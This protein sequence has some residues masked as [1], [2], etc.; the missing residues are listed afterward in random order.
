MDP[1]LQNMHQENTFGFT[2]VIE[3]TL[4]ELHP[5]FVDILGLRFQGLSLDAIGDAYG[6]T[7]ERIRQLA[8]QGTIEIRT[9]LDAFD[10]W[11]QEKIRRERFVGQSSLSA[12]L[13]VQDDL[14][15][16]TLIYALGWNHFQAPRTKSIYWTSEADPVSIFDKF[17]LALAPTKLEDFY[18]RAIETYNEPELI[19]SF[20][21]ASTKVSI[22][23]PGLLVRNS[24]KVRDAS[25]LIFR[26]EGRSLATVNLA[27]RFKMSERAIVAQL[28]RD[29]RFTRD[30]RS[31]VWELSEWTNRSVSDVR[32]A[33]EAVDK[34]LLEHGPLESMRLI[35]LASQL[36]PRS[37]ARYQQV[38]EDSKYGLNSEGNWDFVSNGAQQKTPREPKPNDKV[39]EAPGGLAKIV[40]DVNAE[41]LRGSGV[42]VNRRL[43]WIMGLYM[44]TK[45][46]AFQ[47]SIFPIKP[48]M[49]HRTPGGHNLSALKSF[50]EHFSL[51]AGCKLEIAFDKNRLLVQL[52]PGCDCHRSV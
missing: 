11:L 38:L 41:L 43:T 13:N 25:Y 1:D 17:A 35:S 48:L 28:A 40:V 39:Q 29:Q 45:E 42:Q 12:E 37:Y 21:L 10:S 18:L 47:N 8:K 33:F 9:S 6:L 44:P 26:D 15:L 32:S 23:S 50:A 27:D 24:A 19:N 31:G 14:R 16:T 36:Y 4:D 22:I 7:R 20:I 5:R 2:E 46:L 30:S 49:L 3:R 51:T 52:R 34:I